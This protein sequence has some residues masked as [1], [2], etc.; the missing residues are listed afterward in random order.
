MAFPSVERGAQSVE[1]PS[2]PRKRGST[3]VVVAHLWS[4]RGV[5]NDTTGGSSHPRGCRPF[6][7]LGAPRF[8]RTCSC[9][10]ALLPFAGLCP[11][12][13]ALTGPCPHR[14]RLA[15]MAAH[16]APPPP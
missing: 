6:S 12:P 13:S 8:D 2:S 5:S 7:T 9:P 16:P 15:T 1:K 10:P 4:R 14:A 11:R 3:V